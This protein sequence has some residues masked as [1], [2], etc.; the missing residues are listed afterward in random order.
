MEK[1]AIIKKINDNANCPAAHLCGCIYTDDRARRGIVDYFD[2]LE[3]A[4]AELFRIAQ[5]SE[6]ND[7]ASCPAIWSA[8]TWPIFCANVARLGTGSIAARTNRNNGCRYYHDSDVEGYE[9]VPVIHNEDNDI[10]QHATLL[11]S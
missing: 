11:Y 4:N 10:D 5:R 3:E 2:T 1:Y 8:R 7:P 9:V 6:D